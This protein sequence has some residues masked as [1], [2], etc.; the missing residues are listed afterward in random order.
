METT[1]QSFTQSHK[2][3][4]HVKNTQSEDSG[5]RDVTV[6]YCCVCGRIHD[7]TRQVQKNLWIKCVTLHLPTR[8]SEPGSRG[9]GFSEIILER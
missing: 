5:Q 6:V 9:G 1:E 8:I 4:S 3:F 7:Q 2:M